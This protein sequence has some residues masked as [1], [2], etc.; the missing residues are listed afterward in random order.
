MIFPS[1]ILKIERWKWNKDYGCYVSNQG[2]FKDRH[3]RRLPILINQ[4]GYITIKT[5]VG[6]ILAHRLVM[7]TWRP[8]PN[9]EQLTVDHLD[10]NKRN[11][12]VENLEWVSREENQY[13]A[14]KDFVATAQQEKFSISIG[15]TVEITPEVDRMSCKD[16]GKKCNFYLPEYNLWFENINDVATWFKENLTVCKN[17]TLLTNK[18]IREGVVKGYK[19]QKSY[20]LVKVEMYWKEGEVK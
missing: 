13:R 2:H 18:A 14:T 11:N 17:N 5:E 19:R 20:N 15:E 1:I 10:H 6:F 8:I 7:F 16:L 4:S 9:A 3:K 12:A